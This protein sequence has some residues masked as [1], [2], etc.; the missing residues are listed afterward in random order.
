MKS[1]I[2]NVWV[3]QFCSSFSRL[4]WLFRVLWDSIWILEWTFS[5]S[6]KKCLLNFDRDGVESIDYLKSSNP[7]IWG[8]FPS[9]FVFFNY[10][11]QCF[12]VFIEHLSFF[13]LVM[14]VPV[15]FFFMLLQM[16]FVISFSD[17]SFLVYREQLLSIIDLATC[18]FA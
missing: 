18:Y 9:I 13:F 11:Q 2:K 10:F 16:N 5:I 12:V 4:F 6:A 3:L 8:V 14:F 15:L 7:C 17:C 1:G